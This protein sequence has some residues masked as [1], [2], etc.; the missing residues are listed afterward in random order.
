MNGIDIKNIYKK[1]STNNYLSNCY[2]NLARSVVVH[3]ILILIET[4]LNILNILDL[5]LN[6]FYRQKEKLK[7]IA[8]IPLL[9]KRLSQTTKL[10]MI[11]FGVVVF[12]S[13]HIVLLIKDFR[14]K[15]AYIKIIINFLELFH[16][17]VFLLMFLY[18]FFS[19][20]DMYFLIGLIFIVFHIYLIINNFLY[21]H[22]YYYV[23]NFINYPYDVF[24]SLYDIILV[25]Y[26]ILSSLAYYSS[27]Q[28]IGIFF[29]FLLL[30]SRIL[31]CV[32]FFE[33]TRNHSY[34]LMKNTFL[35]KTRN[36]SIWIETVIMIGALIIGKDELRSIYFILVC[37]C[38]FFII[39]IYI[40]LLYNPYQFIH[41]ETETPN[42]NLY[43]YFYALSS[44]NSL[45]YIFED[46]IKQHFDKC[47]YCFICKKFVSYLLKNNKLNEE[48]EKVYF[49][50]DLN[51]NEE[52]SEEN[53]FNVINNNAH[54][55][56]DKNQLIDLFDVIYDGN[57]KY[58]RL[59]KKISENYQTKSKKFSINNI[60][61]YFINLSFLIYSDYT[62]YNINLSLNEKVI[63]EE[64]SQNLELLDHQTKI[65]QLLLCNN[66]LET[67]KSV[68]A[69]MREILNSEQNF[70]RA[71]KLIDLSFLLTELKESKYKKNLFNTKLEN[72]TNA[73]NLILICSIFYEEIFNTILNNNQVPIRNNIQIL[74][75]TFI[76][77]LNKNDKKISLAL[78]LDNKYCKIIRAGKGLSSHI[79]ENLFELFPLE[80][81]QYQIEHFT[82]TI[83]NNFD[84][85]IL[86][87]EKE[88]EKNNNSTLGV[89]SY[90]QVK[91]RR[92]R[93][94]TRIGQASSTKLSTGFNSKNIKNKKEF[95]KIEIIICQNI[96]SKIYYQLVTLKLTPLFNSDFNYFILLDGVN[97]IHKHAVITV[98]EQEQNHS[99]EENIFSISE[100]KL[101]F[102]TEMQSVP[103]KRYKKWLN[104]QGF[105]LSKV[106]AFNI[107]SK[108]Y[109]LYMVLSK[110]KEVR[111]KVEKTINNALLE[112]KIMEL[113]ENEP[114]KSQIR[115][116]ARP[117]INYIKDTASFFSQQLLNSS[118]RGVNNFGFKN[119]RS[120]ESEQ[121]TEFLKIRKIAYFLIILNIIII[122]VQ[123]IHLNSSENEI[124][125]NNI[126]FLDFREFYKTYF[127]LFSM[128][129]SISC[130]DST[131]DNCN[132]IISFYT[133]IYFRRYPDEHFDIMAFLHLQNKALTLDLMKKRSIFNN[134]Y[135]YI[136][137]ERY[138]DLLRKRVSYLKINKTY[139]N[140]E[141]EYSI[142]ELK[143][144][145][146]ELLIIMCNNFKYITESNETTT[147]IYF[148]NGIDNTFSNFEVK[149]K[150][151]E[152]NLYQQYI[153]ELIINHKT[154]SQ[155]FDNINDC[156]KEMLDK[157]IFRFQ[158]FIYVYL[159][160]NIIIIIAIEIIIY[161]YIG[162]FEKILII[163]L[164]K[165]NMTLNN[166]MEEIKFCE[167]FSEK[168]DNLESIINLSNE[169]PKQSLR[170]M[171][172]IYNN[173][174]QYLIN[175]KKKE[176]RDA[177]KK[178][179]K[180]NTKN[181]QK[182]KKIKESEE[183]PKNQRIVNTSNVRSLR[184]LTK[185][186]IIYIILI[187]SA[188]VLYI[189]SM[190]FWYSYF[191]QQKNLYIILEKD[192]TLETA[193]YRAINVYYMM[194]FNNF[195]V[196][197]ATEV[198]YP[199]VYQ[200][201][202]PLDL[203][204]YIYSSLK[205][206]FNNKIEIE[207]LG[208]LYKNFDNIA[209]YS[210][211]YLYKENAEELLELYTNEISSAVNIQDKL[212]NMCMNI[213]GLDCDKS[214][215]FI[216][217]HF[218][219]IKNGII[220]LDDFTY[221]GIIAHLKLGYLGR[222]SL[223]FNGMMTFL[224]NIIYSKRRSIAIERILNMLRNDIQLTGILFVL[225]DVILTF[226]IIFLFIRKIKNYCNQIALLK[227]AFQ[228]T[229]VEL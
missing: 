206:G 205:L 105:F 97:F 72:I 187:L 64:I 47:G 38:I 23:P 136:G 95:V 229:K 175:K 34:L 158:I 137:A 12:D 41:I 37:V 9:F 49:N 74:E 199:Q 198:L 200:K 134:V 179:Y 143:E 186:F 160:L 127:Q 70:S 3:F 156:L 44:E 203:F 59:L 180:M 140:N 215:Y 182:S 55:H 6:N 107:Y 171:S 169:S 21:C 149:Y 115:N 154:F 161:V 123:Y 40:H 163:I 196:D 191:S 157:R 121:H 56:E 82:Q 112:T 98:L 214:L 189:L 104:E 129:L 84:Y 86:E 110:N 73:K 58:M 28:N 45:S 27:N 177:E 101:E 62:K 221:P 148:L 102:E 132:N 26:K 145:F 29:F 204:K 201:S 75:D 226:V 116:S 193:I 126:T 222:V 202:E 50:I 181:E 52:N 63:L 66:F 60:E 224:I 42:E 17:R 220:I 168:I 138:N 51:Q 69:K 173:Y 217:N 14:K 114:E 90:S 83:I 46:R 195:T 122:I 113:E 1:I 153:Y 133:D 166:K 2:R 159:N 11:I 216:E 184:L 77:N 164:N 146:S 32:F 208:N 128:V 87:K 88:K 124:E 68:I 33:K 228:I 92:T 150:K 131:S 218:Q 103:L 24:S 16:F 174:Q 209:Q 65:D 10:L 147:I 20:E 211:V 71:Q 120:K 99:A 225:Y 144:R 78:S 61:Y 39:V 8:P 35:N 25:Y 178:G 53:N 91:R 125:S 80:F 89:S 172:S 13:M 183:V 106:L 192:T 151:I 210:C 109:Y 165:I 43:F 135:K 30:M 4:A 31:F 96:D 57:N 207:N 36:S 15:K 22:L 54:N 85:N 176:A 94:F 119:K 100:P 48:D 190:I 152:I 5:I 212:T 19:L 219:Y 7:Y 67:S 227:N 155:E 197:Y 93:C 108:I 130:I 162:Y 76:N 81:K 213:I 167:M 188:I 170:N 185:Y 118:D 111:K 18:L 223:F 194:I 141:L 142:I 139:I 79:N 117:K